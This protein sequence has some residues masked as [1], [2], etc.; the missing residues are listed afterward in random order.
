M[1]KHRLKSVSAARVKARRPR[2]P[3]ANIVWRRIRDNFDDLV[4]RTGANPE[5]GSTITRLVL[6]GHLTKGEGQAA[7][8]YG[9]IVGRFDRFHGSGAPRTAPS[10]SYQRGSRG[11][12]DEI[13][14]RTRDGTLASHERAARRARKQY[15]RLHK[16]V[17]TFGPRAR[18]ALDEVC[19]YD[20]EV[21]SAMLPHIAIVL[22]AVGEAFGMIRPSPAKGQVAEKVEERSP[23]GRDAGVV[24]R[25]L[26]DM[27]EREQAKMGP[28]VAYAV[29][30]RERGEI[31]VQLHSR[32]EA[33]TLV[34]RGAFT[35]KARDVPRP[36]L[37]A[38]IHAACATRGYVDEEKKGSVA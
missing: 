5:I 35:V 23:K 25:A 10:P 18:E 38:A 17:G 30:L 37:L 4:V 13:E 26:I 11:S 6:F 2:H 21:P 20:R 1:A 15:D 31:A 7:R 3:G 28:V 32:A 27:I 24:A 19:I 9:E 36:L 33:G 34:S 16:L 22:R 29:H 14:R 12:E 8:M